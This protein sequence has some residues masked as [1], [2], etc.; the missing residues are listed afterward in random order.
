MTDYDIIYLTNIPAFYKINLFNRIVENRKIFVV[1]I[2]DNSRDRNDDFVKGDR[3]FDYVTLD[4]KNIM[5]QILIIKKLLRRLNYQVLIIDGWDYVLYW[6]SAFMSPKKK[7]AV[8]VESSIFDSQTSGLKG[9]FKKIY[10]SR[11]SKS[12]ASG[13]SQKQLLH[14][15][16]FKGSIVITRGVGIFNFNK[17]PTYCPKEEIKNF[18]FVGRLSSEKNLEFLIQ[19]FNKLPEYNLNIVGYGPLESKL[20]KIAFPNVKF[21]GAIDNTLLQSFYNENDALILPSIS[22]VW[23][24]VVEEALNNGLPVI[25]SDKVGCAGEILIPEYNGIIFS[26]SEDQ[27]LKEAI[28]KMADVEYHNKLRSNISQMDYER[29]AEYQVACYL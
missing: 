10:L 23:G 24:L 7:N 26:L 5:S 15:L 28:I 29:T 1:F 2:E 19:T 21:H 18:I 25:V 16:R 8:V 17:Q 27:S 20:K 22:E 12:Y 13:T 11:I 14:A 3:N 6:F 9:L 4:G